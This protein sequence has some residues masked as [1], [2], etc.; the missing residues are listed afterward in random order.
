MKRFIVLLQ[1][2]TRIPINIS[3]RVDEEDFNKAVVYFPLVGF[4]IGL[5]LM[6]VDY[7]LLKLVPS[8]AALFTVVTMIGVTGG[9][10]LDGLGDTFDG[11]YSNRG[12]ERI[13]EIMKDS[14][15]G[16]NAAL[17][18]IVLIL[19]KVGLVSS[20][21][22]YDYVFPVLLFTPVFA[23][24]N[25]VLACRVANYARPSGMGNLFIGKVNN[26]QMII[27][28][29]TT[30]IPCLLFPKLLIPGVITSLFAFYYVK[31]VSR[32]IDGMT[33]D[34][35]G[36]MVEISELLFLFASAIVLGL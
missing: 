21:N 3:I 32:I 10:H 25:V 16:T 26:G 28:I 7:A 8:V 1:F 29:L 23:R 36:A 24:L 31:H 35:I 9:L 12:K 19:G 33:G 17:V 4:V 18:L 13:L 30:Y 34:T 6:S 27:A 14:R 15:L 2:L 20:I 11:L 5:I 22:G